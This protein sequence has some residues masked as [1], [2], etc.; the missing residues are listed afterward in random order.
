M[1][2]VAAI[3]RLALAPA[4]TRDDDRLLLYVRYR[5]DGFNQEIS[6]VA[7]ELA[8]NAEDGAE[9]AVDLLRSVILGL[10]TPHGRIDQLA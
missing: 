5:G 9:R 2:A 8:V 1:P 4:A 7:N 10:Q 6:A 3:K